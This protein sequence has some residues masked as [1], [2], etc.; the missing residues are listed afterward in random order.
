[1]KRKIDPTRPAR[2]ALK[3]DGTPDDNDR[4]ETGPTQL[5]FDEWEARGLTVPDLN[6][7]REYR[8]NRVR[9]KMADRDIPALLLFDPV[10]IRY[11]ADTTNMQVWVMHNLSR[12]CLAL[13]DGPVILWE[14]YGCDHLSEHL[15]LV[16]ELR[17]GAGFI[18]LVAAA[19]LQDMAENF[20][21]EIDHL[22]K[23]HCGQDRRLAVDKIEIA[24][25]RALEAAGI[26]V[27]CGQ[28]LMEHARIIKNE[29]EI[30][31]IKCSLATTEAAMSVVQQKMRPGIT[32]NELWATLH[33]ENIIRGGEWIETRLLASGP[34]TNPWFQECGPRVIRE[35]DI[36]ALDTDL[37]GPYGYCADIS[38]SWLCGEVKP[39]DTQKELYKVAHEE[40]QHNTERVKPGTGFREFSEKSFPVPDKYSAQRYTAMVH[41][42]G[43]C[44]EYPVI[45]PPNAY[46][47]PTINYDGALQPGMTLC[48][49]S[50]VG[51]V[52]AKEGVKLEEQVL[53]TET[54]YETLS[55]YSFEAE[56]LS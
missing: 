20:A 15:P 22:M 25:L 40:I 24:G 4:I 8:L 48:I 38:R 34:R 28:E 1:M 3:P 7:L 52:G 2:L 18:Y 19:G 23:K 33:Y 42:V 47:D 41:G 31:A 35:G 27:S 43:L 55:S 14:F 11:A 16:D 49:E 9:K 56:F 29:N 36:V 13:A 21:A 51:E 53:V 26:K 10:N 50:Y 17:S 54:G 5:A 6:A 45:F 46:D 44:D 30:N 12:A 37:I 39:T 32:E